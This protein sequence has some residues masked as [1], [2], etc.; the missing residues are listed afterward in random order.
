MLNLSR[1]E[2]QTQ[3]GEEVSPPPFQIYVHKDGDENSFTRLHQLILDGAQLQEA[4]QAKG[5]ICG[6]TLFHSGL[7]ELRAS[8]QF[9]E[10]EYPV[11]NKLE[12]PEVMDAGEGRND[13]YVFLMTGQVRYNVT[14]SLADMPRSR[15]SS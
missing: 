6:L 1:L 7:E 14:H 2:L 4:P 3:L 10:E 12:F 5:I 11:T 9:S 15:C 13:F 8:K